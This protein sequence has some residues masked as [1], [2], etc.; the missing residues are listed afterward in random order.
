M[1]ISISA[2]LEASMHTLNE[3]QTL[4]ERL[5]EVAARGTDDSRPGHLRDATNSG[6]KNVQPLPS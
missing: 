4:L 1:L 6:K 2:I 5:K 3:G